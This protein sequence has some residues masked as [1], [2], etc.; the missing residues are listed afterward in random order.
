MRIDCDET[1]E[2]MFCKVVA[3]TATSNDANTLY[4]LYGHE[5]RYVLA[6]F[7]NVNG[8]LVK[9]T[10]STNVMDPDFELDFSNLY[11]GGVIG[12]CRYGLGFD[13]SVK[14]SFFFATLLI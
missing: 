2:F 7:Q 3:P 6:G 8:E 14:K 9:I 11:G 13:Q 12:V 4:M 1:P 5:R 10:S